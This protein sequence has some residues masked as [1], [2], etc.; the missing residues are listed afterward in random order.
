MML[1]VCCFTDSLSLE[2]NRHR[3][4]AA[5]VALVELDVGGVGIP[6]A[7]AISEVPLW[8]LLG[9]SELWPRPLAR[10]VVFT[11]SP[12]RLYVCN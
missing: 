9:R 5:P 10:Y 2:A 7:V 3:R 11:P 1:L 8:P 4:V 12:Y 6:F